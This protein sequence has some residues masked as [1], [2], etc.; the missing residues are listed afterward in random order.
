MYLQ[1]H[2]Y[3]ASTLNMTL[4]AYTNLTST[5]LRGST[6]SQVDVC[7]GMLGVARAVDTRFDFIAVKI[8]MQKE[9]NHTDVGIGFVQIIFVSSLC[10]F[11]SAASDFTLL[12]MS[13]SLSKIATW[14]LQGTSQ[15]AV[16][17]WW[18]PV[19]ERES[20]IHSSEIQLYFENIR[21]FRHFIRNQRLSLK[22]SAVRICRELAFADSSL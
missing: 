19:L 20:L 11:R 5:C 17:V 1:R 6:R 7:F 13:F 15:N 8:D 2:I 3:N 9:S 18:M 10:E 4:C 12:L 14:S 16:W 21:N 22:S